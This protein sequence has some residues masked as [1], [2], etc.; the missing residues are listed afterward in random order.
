LEGQ[1][2]NPCLHSALRAIVQTQDFPQAK[3]RG[4][5]V[6]SRALAKCG[7]QADGEWFIAQLTASSH[8]A[9]QAAAERG[10]KQWDAQQAARAAAP[11]RRPDPPPA[12]AANGPIEIEF[13]EI[14]P[15]SAASSAGAKQLGECQ[16]WL[17]A[18][19]GDLVCGNGR[20]QLLKKQGAVVQLWSDPDRGWS[21]RG[22]AFGRP[23]GCFDGRYAWIPLL[24]AGR[25]QRLLTIDV[26]GEKVVEWTRDDGLPLAEHES[27]QPSRPATLAV[28]P[29]GPGKVCIAGS[30]GRGW[31]A[32]AEFSA[33][34]EKSAKVFFEARNE[35]DP[36]N[37]REALK[38][39]L[40]FEPLYIYTLSG[41]VQEDQPVSQR[42]M[43]GRS[44]RHPGADLH[45]LL[46]DPD[47]GTVLALAEELKPTTWPPNARSGRPACSAWDIRIFAG[48]W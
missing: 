24:H 33:E 12:P 17:A 26:R 32:T 27:G 44:T 22:P 37:G 18:D 46:V 23:L 36:S 9:L 30:S 1:T 2:G 38:S 19:V 42:V 7:P 4:E 15:P 34:R 21:P 25:P 31:L 47:K 16:L 45:P 40:A 48:N 29:L 35:P 13:R 5:L 10:R 28:T 3:E 43:V 20:V 41:R 8:P 11:V 14:K 39:N 6:A